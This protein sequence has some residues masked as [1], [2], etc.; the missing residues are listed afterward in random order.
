MKRRTSLKRLLSLSLVVCTLLIS[1]SAR[2]QAPKLNWSEKGD[3]CWFRVDG[4]KNGAFFVVN[5]EER[6][7]KPAFDRE[8]L[9]TALNELLDE[10]ITTSNLDI[11]RIAWADSEDALLIQ[12]ANW[13]R[14]NT[15]TY[16]LEVADE[17]IPTTVQDQLFL[18]PR[19]SGPSQRSIHI[20]VKNELQR[21]ISLFWVSSDRGEHHYAD[22]APGDSHRQHTYEG[23]S[24][25][26]KSTRDLASFIAAPNVR[27][28]LD[29]QTL[30]NVKIGQRRGWGRRPR[31]TPPRDVSRDRVFIRN[32]NL[33]LR[34]E[35]GE[36]SQLSQDGTESNTFATRRGDRG[37]FYRSPDGKFLV[38]MQRT[39]VP[40]RAIQIVESS[41]RDQLQPRLIE[42]A[43][44]KPGDQLP[45]KTVHLYS[46]EDRTEI[47]VSQSL[48][49]NQW[50]LD[51]G[52]W[53]ESGDRFYLRFNQRGH[54]VLRELEVSVVDGAVRTLIEETSDTFIQ[55][56]DRGKSVRENLTPDEILWASERSGW[57]HLYRF[58]RTTGELI[59]PVTQGDWNVKRIE[60]IDREHQEIWFYAVG[61]LEDQDPYHEH[62]CRVNFD[63]SE[64]NVLSE[65]DGTHTIDFQQERRYFVDTWSRVDLAPVH[66]LRDS[67]SGELIC[68]LR[69]EDTE[70][71]F[72]ERR[73]TERFVAK[74]R[75]GE[76]DIW[77]IIH[78]PKDF[79]PA[80]KYPVVEN[81]YAGP[82]DHHVP[83]SFRSR[84]R[85]H[86]FADAGMIVVQIDGMGTAWRSKAFHDVCF[87]NLRDAGFPDR[88][89]WIKAA[90]EKYPQMDLT[91]VGI[92]GGSAGGQNAMA[93][94]LWH[95]D[96]Y[97]VAVADCGCHDN[98]MDKIWWNEQWMGWPVDESYERNSNTENAHLLE[99]DL[100]LFVGELDRNV[101]PATTTQVVRELIRHNKDFDFVL[102]PGAG[103]GSAET[104]W[105]SRKRLN[106]LKEKL[107]VED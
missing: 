30:A 16:E 56:S 87:Q 3:R 88:I 48:F 33:W 20:V 25:L 96:F 107:R 32:H 52:G 94:L 71:A 7:R 61:V 102:V 60:S 49:A 17:S 66:E 59:N 22:I 106:F 36:E 38:A 64:F 13:Y 53:S 8:R 101:D 45:Q 31:N 75:D 76:T 77:G 9:A 40:E 80:K 27:L 70:K 23:H 68:E 91:R 67:A 10:E 97:K 92:F 62:L 37:D 72:G 63:G 15:K 50:S 21:P 19:P 78:W 95:S 90:A 4:D 74:G 93:A 24:W 41:P 14:L 44:R 103:H 26:L 98:R 79:D 84:Y 57:N 105:A 35:D 82:H 89:A 34:D 73:L 11:K 81:I 18:P 51:F 12:R 43:Y 55:Y 58:S 29:E 5:V 2:G 47:E 42:L 85:Q 83:K 1:G 100:M 65:G 28:T 39:V 69:R 46:I 104:P 54:Q 86:T 6:Q 99:G